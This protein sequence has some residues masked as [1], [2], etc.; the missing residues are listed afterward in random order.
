MARK[1]GRRRKLRAARLRL[2]WGCASGSAMAPL[3]C[4]ALCRQ[5]VVVAQKAD[6][7][8]TAAALAVCLREPRRATEKAPPRQEVELALL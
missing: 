1:A 3:S 7:S 8:E 2:L 5:T 4:I 6:S